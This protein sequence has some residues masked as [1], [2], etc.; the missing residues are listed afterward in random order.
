MGDQGRGEAVVCGSC[1]Q[2][3][4][5]QTPAATAAWS[6]VPVRI[7]SQAIALHHRES[8]D[9]AYLCAPVPQVRASRQ[10]HGGAQH[11]QP[12]QQDLLGQPSALGEDRSQ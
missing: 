4:S 3:T 6:F 2:F 5:V 9:Q 10:F 8:I 12:S 7:S 11:S 1:Q